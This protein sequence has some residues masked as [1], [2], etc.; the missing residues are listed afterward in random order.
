M[1]F[2]NQIKT[3]RL[4]NGEMVSTGRNKSPNQ[5]VCELAERLSTGSESGSTNVSSKLH[6]LPGG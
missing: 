2:K 4:P 5:V 6:Y 1:L 3:H